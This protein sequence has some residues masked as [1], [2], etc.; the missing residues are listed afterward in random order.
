MEFSLTPA[1][2]PVVAAASASPEE[3][4]FTAVSTFSSSFVELNAN[5]VIV[6]P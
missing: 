6:Q 3:S 5:C 4:A 1:V 2:E